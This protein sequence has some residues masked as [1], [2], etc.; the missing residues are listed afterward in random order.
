MTRSDDT[1]VPD[2]PGMLRMDGRGV[3][4]IGAGQGI[5]RQTCHAL[6]QA[7]AKVLCVDLDP[8][9]AQDITA[10]VDGVA[11]VGNATIRA[12][13]ERLFAAAPGLLA[14]IGASALGGIVDIVGMAQTSC[15]TGT[16]TS[17]SATPIW[18][19]RWA[20]ERCAT[21]GVASWSSWPPRRA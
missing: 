11:W 21:R 20:V 10:E 17:C 15:G 14:G 19:C 2:Y 6:A 8:D 7:G 4:V 3:V 9:L 1:A 5:G 18:P 16:T 12:D 13:A